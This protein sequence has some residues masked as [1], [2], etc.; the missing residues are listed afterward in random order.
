MDALIDEQFL[1][2]PWYRSRQM[3]RR[4]RPSNGEACGANDGSSLGLVSRRVSS[5]PEPLKKKRYAIKKNSSVVGFR[6]P[7]EIDD[8]L[9]SI[10]RS[11]ARQ[12][13]TQAVEIEAEAFQAADG[14][15]RVVRH[16]HS[17]SA[18]SRRGSGRLRSAR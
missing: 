8:S 14:R 9:T 3:A 6:Q 13:L 7:D 16:G 10:L 18:R 1:E 4:L 12:L 15:G 11:G 2:T 17:P 5:L